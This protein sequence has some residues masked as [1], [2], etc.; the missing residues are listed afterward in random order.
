M[1]KRLKDEDQSDEP[2]PRKTLFLLHEDGWCFSENSINAMQLHKAESKP[3][4]V[5]TG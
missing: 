1:R 3:C 4:M 5:V 2:S